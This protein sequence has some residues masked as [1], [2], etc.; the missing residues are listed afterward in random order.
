VC[1][2]HPRAA[3]A[4]LKRLDGPLPRPYSETRATNAH[5]RTWA[6]FFY[7]SKAVRF[8]ILPSS[9]ITIALGV[10]LWLLARGRLTA[11]RRTLAAALLGVLGCGALPLGDWLIGPLERRFQR[12][13]L[14][15]RRIATIIVLGGAEETSRRELMGLNDAAERLTEAAALAHRY[16]A[17][18]LLFTGGSSSVIGP[19]ST[20]AADARRLF[21]ALGIAPQRIVLE[22]QSRTTWEN[23]VYTCKL[24]GCRDPG[25]AVGGTHLLVTT[26][27][28][29]PRSMGTFRAAGMVV[30]PWPVDYR[31]AERYV[32]GIYMI[33]DGLRRVDTVMREYFGMLGY[34]ITG[35]SSALFPGPDR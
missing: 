12:P 25:K 35:R 3:A 23:A 31:T 13:D 2:G 6:L 34:R 24:M 15:D 9:M 27:M 22:D 1:P 20:G 28:H 7:L 18:T 14:K 17:A 26:A 19:H 8:L 10:A 33:P 11:G 32:F 4:Q 30:E 5:H 16:P 21:E 29:M